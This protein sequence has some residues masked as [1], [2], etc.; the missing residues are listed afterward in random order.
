[1]NKKIKY[2]VMGCWLNKLIFIMAWYVFFSVPLQIF[3]AG[4][5]QSDNYLLLYSMIISIC[6]L[7]LIK[8]FSNDINSLVIK[9]TNKISNIPLWSIF[10]LGFFARLVWVVFFP[11]EPGSDGSVYMALAEK[12]KNFEEYEISGTKA[13]WPVGYPVFL[14]I[15]FFIFE[16]TKLAYIASNFILYFFAILGV[17]RLSEHIVGEKYSRLSV[18]LLAIWPNLIANIATPEKEMLV[19]AILPWATFFIIKGI[20]ENNGLKCIFFSGVLLGM[21]TLVQPSL[22]F[23]PVLGALFILID[24]GV[25]KNAS[26]KAFIL[27]IASV[28]IISPWTIRNYYK[29]DSFVLVSTNGGSNFYRANNSLATGGYVEKGEIDLSGLDEIKKDEQGKKL[30]KEWILKNPEKF[31]ALILEKEV[32]FMGDDSVG[33]YNTF[34]VGG[35]SI[36]KPY[37]VGLKGIANLFWISIWVFI[38]SLSIKKCREKYSYVYICLWIWLYLFVIHSVFESAGKYHVPVIWVIYII[39]SYLVYNINNGISIN[40]NRVKIVSEFSKFVVVG[41]GATLIQYIVLFLL[42]TYFGYNAV[43]ASSIGFAISSIFNYIFNYYYT[44]SSDISHVTSA[45]RFIIVSVSGL[46]I[47]AVLLWLFIT[48]VGWQYMICQVFATA[49][50]LLWN[51]IVNRAWTFN[52]PGGNIINAEVIK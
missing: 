29:F 27:I 20:K 33:V 25:N 7:G 12:I 16:N 18:L 3:R 9:L 23:L 38:A 8:Y 21:A 47:N 32:R 40:K 1:M 48:F 2:L 46:C 50:T 10:L 41:G 43:L 4:T 19:L 34:K 35:V 26:I 42:V 14:A 11:A 45:P 51:F 31:G 6:M 5:N 36:D 15:W 44:F 22:Q 24:R 17:Y 30:A 52:R 49:G 39:L 37:Y 13:Y 28:I